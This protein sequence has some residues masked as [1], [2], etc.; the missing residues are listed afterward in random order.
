MHN[1]LCEFIREK[2]SK[3]KTKLKSNRRD[4][5]L[6]FM[7]VGTGKSTKTETCYV[8]LYGKRI[9]SEKKEEKVTEGIVHNTL[10]E[11]IREK[12]SKEKTKLKS[13][14]RD[15]ALQFMWVGTGKSIKT[16]TFYVSLYGKKYQKWKRIKKCKSNRRHRAQLF[17]WVYA[18]KSIKSENKIKK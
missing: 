10:C 3:V 15:R 8:S 18:G 6:H 2:V 7:W 4:R 13:N 5:A 14:R 1:I 17:M 9:K 11:F 16:E 12:V